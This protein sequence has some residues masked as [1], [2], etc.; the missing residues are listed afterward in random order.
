MSGIVLNWS[1]TGAG[2]GVPVVDSEVLSTSRLLE[3]CGLMDR[4]AYV[5]AVWG[6]VVMFVFFVWLGRVRERWLGDPDLSGWVVVVD[7]ALLVFV[8]LMFVTVI[9]RLLRAG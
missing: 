4:G 7:K 5:A 6:L 9:V 2:G 8:A 1:F 3:V